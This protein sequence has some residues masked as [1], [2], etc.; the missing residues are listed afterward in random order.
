MPEEQKPQEQKPEDRRQNPESN[1]A[2]QT[3]EL[4]TIKT[5]LEEERKKKIEIETEI[6]KKDKTIAEL[7]KALSEAKQQSEALLQKGEAVTAEF[8]TLK[9]T[10][11]KAVAKYL[12]AV[13]TANPT[14]PADVITGATIEE[15]DAALAKAL[16]IATAVKASLEAQ[17][18]ETKV[19]AGAP[20]RG[21]IA[22]DALS[23]REKIAA[24]LQQRTQ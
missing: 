11:T 1:G 10:H 14:L 21:G 23:P 9:D 12:A 7:E 4:A 13:K 6:A 17:A 2:A 22:L 3:D 19:P 8:A 16:T 18:K 20:T 5:E 24:G 15:I